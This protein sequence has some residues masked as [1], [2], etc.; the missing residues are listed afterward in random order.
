MNYLSLFMPMFSKR[1][2][3]LCTLGILALVAAFAMWSLSL[4]PGIVPQSEVADELKT[5]GSIYYSGDPDYG[6]GYVPAVYRYSFDADIESGMIADGAHAYAGLEDEFDVMVMY[7]PD[8]ADPDEYQ[9][10]WRSRLTGEVGSLL[11]VNGY[12][13]TDLSVAPDETH[14]AYSFQAEATADPYAIADWSIAIHNYETGEY[15]VLPEAIEPTWTYG[16]KALIYMKQDGLHMYDVETSTSV[17]LIEK[18]QNLSTSDDIASTAD[19]AFLVLTLPSLNRIAVFEERPNTDGELEYFELPGVFDTAARFRHPVVHPT[20]EQF[21]VVRVDDAN[22][23]S[24]TDSYTA[25]AIELRQTNNGQ[26]VET[27]AVE[28]VDPNTIRLEA[29]RR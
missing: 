20:G 4:T 9:P 13:E 14:Y 19:G 7:Q 26:L 21:A 15:T 28:D 10:V 6:G 18:Y 23:D 27:I 5:S 8:T 3:V 22:Y 24:A 1:Q 16:G 25:A 11:H 29:W 17:K 2:M 12:R